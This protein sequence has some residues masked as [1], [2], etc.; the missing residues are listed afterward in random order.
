MLIGSIVFDHVLVM[1]CV[2]YYIW[3]SLFDV[4]GLLRHLQDADDALARAGR[5][6]STC[7]TS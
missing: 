1:L 4:Y 7:H 2:V 6:G 5:L 3:F